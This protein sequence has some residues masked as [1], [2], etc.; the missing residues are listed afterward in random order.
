M[1]YVQTR[2]EASSRELARCLRKASVRLRQ[3]KADGGFGLGGTIIT[4]LLRGATLTIPLSA[5][6]REDDGG[7]AEIDFLLPFY[8]R[9]S[10]PT[11]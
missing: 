4:L 2:D 10:A 7:K 3:R 5:L 11:V 1:G 9:Q 8:I 6:I